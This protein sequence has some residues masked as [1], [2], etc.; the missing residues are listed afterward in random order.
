[1]RDVL[2]LI[3]ILLVIIGSV[4]FAQTETFILPGET[5]SNDAF[6]IDT[7]AALKL[8]YDQKTLGL[9]E[10]VGSG[11]EAQ[12]DA[13]SHQQ[14]V[15]ETPLQSAEGFTWGRNTQ[16]D[17]ALGYNFTPQSDGHIT[18]LGGFLHGEK[19]VR[20]FHRATGALLAETTVAANNDWHYA[21]VK[22]VTVVA[23]EQYTV[24]VYLNGSGGSYGYIGRRYPV[25][26][27]S[28]NIDGM[29]YVYTGHDS[30]TFTRPS[31]NVEHYFMFGQ[32][33]VVFVAEK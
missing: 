1:M 9:L 24:A 16:W 6:V 18:A 4:V 11:L 7:P 27:G 5:P 3:T 28:V 13:V 2:V 31:N 20:L 12:W 19:I 21:K 15:L 26:S 14:S 32:A 30:D 25:R 17:F 10:G 8:S 29:T 23:G 22:P 33:D